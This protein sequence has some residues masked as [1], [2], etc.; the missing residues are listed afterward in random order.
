MEHSPGLLGRSAKA[1]A[2]K[3]TLRGSEEHR[4]TRGETYCSDPRK[5][6]ALQHRLHGKRVWR[7]PIAHVGVQLGPGVERNHRPAVPDLIED[8]LQHN[9]A[10]RHT[11][12]TF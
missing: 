6:Y 7:P 3:S 5:A 4:R 9:V 11:E 12:N 8:S 2:S 10:F 1:F